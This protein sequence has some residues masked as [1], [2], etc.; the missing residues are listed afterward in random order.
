MTCLD[1]EIDMFREQGHILILLCPTLPFLSSLSQLLPGSSK[2]SS[3]LVCIL[4]VSHF[5]TFLHS[6]AEEGCIQN[7]KGPVREGQR[8]KDR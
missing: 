1:E 2:F 7:A 5:Q 4:L 8:L 6:S 3:L